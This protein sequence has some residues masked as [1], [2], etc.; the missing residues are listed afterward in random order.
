MIYIKYYVDAHQKL[1]CSYKEGSLFLMAV[2]RRRPTGRRTPLYLSRDNTICINGMSNNSIDDDIT[3][4]IYPRV[5]P[6][7]FTGQKCPVSGK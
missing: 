5:K 4:T 2:K 3:M 7:I 1:F 6:N